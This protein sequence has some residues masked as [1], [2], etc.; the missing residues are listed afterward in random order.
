MLKRMIKMHFGFLICAFGI[1]M[2]IN[3]NIGYTPWDVFHV[4]LAKTTGLT[5]GLSS[6]VVS[7]TIIAL[8]IILGEKIGVGTI[9]NMIVI[10]LLVDFIMYLKIIPIADNLSIGIIMFII[11]L[12]LFGFG[13][14]FYISAGFGAGPRDGLMVILTKKTS[15]SVGV[16]R[17]FIECLATF[18]GFLLGGKVG[19]GTIIGATLIGFIVAW[20]FKLFNFDAKT[21]VHENLRETILRLNKI[22][23]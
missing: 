9:L 15:F 17:G 7:F 19:I 23:R 6:I 4:G 5:I 20:V 21:L 13:T 18:F 2:S 12:F 8:T 1:V 10:G 14:Y 11:S 22:E 3:A 16:C